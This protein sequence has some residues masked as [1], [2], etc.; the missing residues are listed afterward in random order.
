MR[1]FV[2]GLCWLAAASSA[3]A[4][5][6]DR[7]GPS[8]RLP[9][10]S[11]PQARREQLLRLA[12]HKQLEAIERLKVLIATQGHHPENH[13][14]MMLRL[15]SLYEQEGRRLHFRELDVFDATW[16]ACAARPDCDEDLLRPDHTTSAKWRGDA[17]R[18]LTLLLA[19]YPT[20]ARAD[21]AA[22]LL[23]SL[24][25]DLERPAA[26][27][28]V[29]KGLLRRHPESSLAPDALVLLGD[30][31][32]DDRGDPVAALRIYRRATAYRDSPLYSYARYRLAWCLYN[33]GEYEPAIDAMKSVALDSLQNGDEERS[34]GLG[35]EA[36]RDLVRFYADAD[37]AADAEAFLV[38]LGRE[39]L[40]RGLYR[41][42]AATWMEQGRFE[43]G[44]DTLRR[45][46]L[47]DPTAEDNPHHQLEI[48]RATR[49]LGRR[50][51]VLTEL[52]TLHDTYGPGSSWAAANDPEAVEEV[53][54]SV[55]E[56][57]RQLAL[58]VHE[59]ARRYEKARRSDDAAARYALARDAYETWLGWFEGHE[60][61]YDVSYAYAELLYAVEDFP[62]AYEAYTRV[63]EL[64]PRGE[65]SPF[66][67]E[68]AVFAAE[69]MLEQAPRRERAA[70]SPDTPP[71]PL[72]EWE[73][74]YLAAIERHVALYPG[75]KT[76]DL[77]YRSAYLLYSRVH[78][79]EAAEQFRAVI[80]LDPRS[81]EAEYAAQLIL[82]AL[83]VRESWEALQQTATAFHAAPGLGSAAFKADVLE[84]V[85]RSSFKVVEARFAHDGD[86]LAAGEGF[87]AFF[88]TH[89]TATTAAQAL[90]N[91]AFH[92]AQAHRYG[93]AT[94]AR[95][96]LVHDPRFGE[97]TPYFVDQLAALGFDHER[98]A[99]YEQAAALYEQLWE[100]AHELRPEVAADALFSA[101]VFRES[102]GQ[103]GP[104]LDD[105]TRFVQARPDDARH[106]DAALRIARLHGE[107]G[108]WSG[109]AGAYLSYA[110]S[111]PVG[112]DPASVPLAWLRYGQA[113]GELGET[114]RRDAAYDEAIA[115]FTRDQEASAPGVPY[116][117]EMMLT[118]VLAE[119]EHY[120]ALR[121]DGPKRAL[122]RHREDRLLT[123]A[124]TEKAVALRRLERRLGEIVELKAGRAGL[125]ALVALGESYENMAH[126]VR[127]SHVPTY[128][129]PE[130]REMY[131]LRLEDQAYAMEEK[132]VHTY[133]LAL[134]Q[135]FA[136]MLYDEHTAV[137]VRRL[138]ELRP[139]EHPALDE[140]LLEPRWTASEP[141]VRP[142]YEATL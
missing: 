109:A 131:G 76:K 120:L 67:A 18:V 137:A 28:E 71:E 115:T 53:V 51:D 59:T 105:Y 61:A 142:A 113:L 26:S 116:V 36:L 75:P 79:E 108:D 54:A 25:R 132:A 124:L 130:Q 99:D 45:L 29:L 121:I 95:R 135:A 52:R 8:F 66:C 17:T 74:R 55:E 31:A 129:T 112:A 16:D 138:G 10:A 56:P 134:E 11:S 122:P 32:F 63:V 85:E 35:D 81:K 97:R 5:D 123:D 2:L 70:I 20:Y 9:D 34:L 42:L 68:S 87:R 65:R 136:L 128:L 23:A 72:S 78:F 57:L 139:E 119:R 27:A 107:L 13:A 50:D 22:F 60:R 44:I 43:R 140:A 100:H 37:Q 12:E 102:L 90:N 41:R 6:P 84:I 21:D 93:D 94:E 141:M 73:Q 82:D 127:T 19:R 69:A 40:V 58:Q 3:W 83:A 125:A 126:T 80:A 110:E 111:P 92:F 91:A 98:I 106:P 49:K 117:A 62:A 33:V 7:D 30:H 1:L 48:V 114:D 47:R 101:A 103:R 88:D 77:L 86:H 24:H 39:D 96:I 38:G 15:A 14:E 46:V 64:D 89:P 104:A 4:A 118:R 133:E